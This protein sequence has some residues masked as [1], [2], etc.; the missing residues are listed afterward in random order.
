[1]LYHMTVFPLSKWAI[2]KID[3]IRRNFLW[4]G[5]EEPKGGH[6]LVS[7]KRVQ[8]PK[9]LGGLGILELSKFNMALRLQWQ[10]FKWKSHSKPWASMT[11]SHTSM[12]SIF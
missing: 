4:Y 8:R 5:Y 1:M 9:K 3:K 6:C 12:E 11:I 2:K 10:W 7:W